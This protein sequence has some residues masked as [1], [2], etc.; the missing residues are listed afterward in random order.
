[1]NILSGIDD[2]KLLQHLRQLPMSAPSRS[3]NLVLGGRVFQNGIDLTAGQNHDSTQVE[4]EHQDNEGAER[5]VKQPKIT[6]V[7][8]VYLEQN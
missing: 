6:E 2:S 7:T 5:A 1:M 3:G 4:P 8:D